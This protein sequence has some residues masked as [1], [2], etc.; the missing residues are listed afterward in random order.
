MDLRTKVAGTRARI[1]PAVELMVKT[2]ALGIV[3]P[4]PGFVVLARHRRL[5]GE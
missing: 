4:S 2:V 1:V 3:Q 5:A